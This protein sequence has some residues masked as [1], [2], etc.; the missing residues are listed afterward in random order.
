MKIIRVIAISLIIVIYSLA[1]TN[2]QASDFKNDE[3]VHE[4][5]EKFCK[6][7]FDGVAERYKHAK[8]TSSYE[9]KKKAEGYEFSGHV[10]MW[11]WDP[12]FVVASY[13]MIDVDVKKM[14][15]IATIDYVRIARS[16]GK[17]NLHSDIEEHDVVKLDLVF[18]NQ[19]RKWLVI[20]PPLPRIS[21]EAL[22]RFYE[23]SLE[24]MY[25]SEWLKNPI[26]SQDEKRGNYQQ[27][28]LKIIK[29]LKNLR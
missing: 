20:D 22:I 2:S 7:E 21:R 18:D 1:M 26:I 11:D 9:A 10:N 8:F 12:F 5:A 3:E 14:H 27:E 15:A 24:A 4:A 17:E 25:G 19:S 13:K 29:F 6:A 28:K 16:E 23:S